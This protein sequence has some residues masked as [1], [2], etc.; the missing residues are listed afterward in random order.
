MLPP[1]YGYT[2]HGMQAGYAGMPMGMHGY[3]G[4]PMQGY[5]ASAAMAT[6]VA[7]TPIPNPAAAYSMYTPALSAAYNAA[8]QVL[9]Q[10]AASTAGQQQQQDTSA[11][12]GEAGPAA[13]GTSDTAPASA[14]AGGSAQQAAAAPPITMPMPQMF[15]QPA[16][17]FVPTL[18]PVPQPVLPA[19]L[20]GEQAAAAVAAQQQQQQGGEG[21]IGAAP[22]AAP[23][24]LQPGQLLMAAPMM[25]YQVYQHPMMHQQH[26]QVGFTYPASGIAA[27]SL[28][29]AQNCL[30]SAADP[31]VP[32]NP[33]MILER[34]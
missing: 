19:Y 10:Q 18:I 4:M 15:Q 6:G 28:P 21:G 7:Y 2:Y 1:G 30:T 3:H 13:A 9:Q 8:L 22:A 20:T 24:G 29:I 27:Y 26:M 12:G 16:F 32:A 11:G 14:S 31:A 17:A 23:P 25:P 5:P 33:W 34:L